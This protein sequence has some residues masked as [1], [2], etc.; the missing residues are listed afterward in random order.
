MRTAIATKTIYDGSVIKSGDRF[1]VEEA[2]FQ[3]LFNL[4]AVKEDAQAAPEEPVAETEAIAS[5]SEKP[6]GGKPV[7]G[8]KK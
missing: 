4:G 2:E 6:K 3:R 7:R 1:Q 5:A 8:A